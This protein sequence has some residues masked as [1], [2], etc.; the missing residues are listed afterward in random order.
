MTRRRGMVCRC[1]R[2]KKLKFDRKSLRDRISMELHCGR[3][4]GVV[5]EIMIKVNADDSQQV[6]TI[7]SANAVRIFLSVW[8]LAQRDSGGLSQLLNFF[9]AHLLD[10]LCKK[11]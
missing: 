8:N 10:T 9:S 11:A 1:R 2:W 7:S 6:Q 5:M 4:G 3:H